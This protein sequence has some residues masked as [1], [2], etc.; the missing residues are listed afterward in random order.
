MFAVE[1]AD[2]RP[3]RLRI[4]LEPDD[5]G[6][7]L[8][9]FVKEIAE[10]GSTIVTD[11]RKGHLTLARAGFEHRR[12]VEGRGK[13]FRD[14]VPHARIAIGNCKAWLTGTHKGVWRRHLVAYLDEFDFRYN[15]RRNLALAF[16]IL[17]GFDVA[18][19]ATTCATI[20]GARDMPKIV[21]TPSTA[22]RKATAKAATAAAAEVPSCGR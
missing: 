6:G 22:T 19:P 15:R 11:G 18:R 1:L 14:P 10:P 20:T 13:A 2:D 12:I 3:I 4:K 17:L 7:S 21:D 16:R 5:L 8:V 9:A